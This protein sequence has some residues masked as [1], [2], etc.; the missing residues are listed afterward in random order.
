[1]R[2]EELHLNHSGLV[3]GEGEDTEAQCTEDQVFPD[4]DE[5]HDRRASR[6]LRQE[7]IDSYKKD[8]AKHYVNS[9]SLYGLATVAL[10]ECLTDKGQY[11]EILLYPFFV[12]TA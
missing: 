10:T 2:K 12:P 8:K 6:K 9:Q 5:L 11:A 3:R 4:E 7:Y 1:M